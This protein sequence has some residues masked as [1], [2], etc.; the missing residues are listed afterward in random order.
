MRF[1]FINPTSSE[2][3]QKTFWGC[4]CLLSHHRDR[5]WVATP[6]RKISGQ[7]LDHFPTPPVL[8]WKQINPKTVELDH[9]QNFWRGQNQK[10]K[11]I[12]YIRYQK[13]HSLPTGGRQ[14]PPP[15]PY[16]NAETAEWTHHLTNSSPS[17]FPCWGMDL[18]PISLKLH[19]GQSSWGVSPK[20]LPKPWWNNQTSAWL[21]LKWLLIFPEM[22]HGILGTGRKKVSPYN[23]ANRNFKSLGNLEF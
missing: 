6:T 20:R 10:K 3:F 11:H 2:W 16:R 1:Q 21:I 15:S 23:Y 14:G 8:G 13:I 4:W 17:P 18:S 9:F 7:Q 12:R 22:F 5:Y 19:R